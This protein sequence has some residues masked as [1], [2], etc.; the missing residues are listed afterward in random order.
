MS[1]TVYL[2]AGFDSVK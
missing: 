2:R 1:D